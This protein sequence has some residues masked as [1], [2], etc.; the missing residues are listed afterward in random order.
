MLPLLDHRDNRSSRNDKI[1]RSYITLLNTAHGID[2]DYLRAGPQ[3]R[4]R[5][6]LK[7]AK[8]AL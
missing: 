8:G 6:K 3:T 1:E 5:A 2:W 4:M 7:L